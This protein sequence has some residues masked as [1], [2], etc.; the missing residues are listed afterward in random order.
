MEDKLIPLKNY[1]TVVEALFEQE[2]LREKNIDS[3]INDEESVNVMPMFGDINEGP[4]IMVFE[5]DYEKA[6]NILEEYN[7]SLDK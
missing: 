3:S 7:N 4:R 5:K 2:L 1:E 6:L